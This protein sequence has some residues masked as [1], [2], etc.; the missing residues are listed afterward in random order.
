MI[1]F[2][3]VVVYLLWL[4]QLRVSYCSSSVGTRSRHGGHFD[5]QFASTKLKKEIEKRKHDGSSIVNILHRGTLSDG[6][7]GLENFHNVDK[8]DFISDSRKYA[9]DETPIYVK[10]VG[11]EHVTKGT[12]L[13]MEYIDHMNYSCTN[14]FVDLNRNNGLLTVEGMILGK[15]N[16]HY[17]TIHTL[18]LK[19]DNSFD[20]HWTVYEHY[21]CTGKRTVYSK[22]Y[23]QTSVCS[24]NFKYMYQKSETAHTLFPDL[25]DKIFI[26][27]EG[28]PCYND[29]EEV[30]SYELHNS[31]FT[32]FDTSQC[33]NMYYYS[34]LVEAVSLNIVLESTLIGQKYES[35]DD[36][37]CA[38]YP[39]KVEGWVLNQCES[40]GESLSTKMNW[41]DIGR[42]S[43][44][45]YVGYSFYNTYDCSGMPELT[46]YHHYG[47]PD[48]CAHGAIVFSHSPE[49]VI[50]WRDWS[51]DSHMEDYSG[52]FCDE[53]RTYHWATY[54]SR[55]VMKENE[56]V[57]FDR[58]LRY[59][60]YQEVDDDDLNPFSSFQAYC[61]GSDNGDDN[62]CFHTSSTV[63]YKGKMYSYS[64]LEAGN[65]PEC[66]VPHTPRSRGLVIIS[67]CLESNYTKVNKTLRVT[68]THLVATTK[69]FQ[70]AYSLKAGDILFGGYADSDTCVVL[71]VEKE[72]KFETY[73]GLNCIHSEI[74]VNG[75]R[76]STFGDFHTLPSWYMAYVGVM[77]G[78]S[79]ASA[80]GE[81]ISD[82][83]YN[84]V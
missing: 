63:T 52:Q 61:H 48:F 44:Y 68:D 62:I 34:I 17:K 27:P 11:D 59:N 36:Q 51:F 18:T 47:K 21:N 72:D 3:T 32:S 82:L 65:E 29:R 40:L 16:P 10:E 76:V 39:I 9:R 78:P 80:V 28:I 4:L 69:G 73:F 20:L 33:W 70:L 1:S 74:L 58:C 8:H 42:H 30:L 25:Q 22:S 5:Q 60:L 14:G 37:Y 46:I 2:P 24:G 79:S 54:N 66:S 49:S 12:F 6:E 35:R 81:F 77:M 67:E 26:M 45:L 41:I 7:Q 56:R 43:A 23:A 64:E 71:T 13:S 57:Q 53:A 55:C 38:G 83:Y 75:I 15:C 84:H 50:S 31:T 19:Y